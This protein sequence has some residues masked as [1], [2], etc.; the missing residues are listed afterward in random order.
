[1]MSRSS[2]ALVESIST[3]TPSIQ[4][5]PAQQCKPSHGLLM[6]GTLQAV[7][8]KEPCRC[9]MP[10]YDRSNIDQDL[11]PG[12]MQAKHSMYHTL[13]LSYYNGLSYQGYNNFRQG[14]HL[15]AL[16]HRK[17]ADLHH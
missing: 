5:E 17:R 15:P 9:G 4:P 2:T 6:A 10:G 1:M 14:S 16:T 12:S 11:E 7:A 8:W 3:P 13:Q